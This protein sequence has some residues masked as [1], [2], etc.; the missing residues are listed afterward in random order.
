MG[1][2]NY[3]QEEIRKFF[4]SLPKEVIERE[5]KKQLQEI[6][7]DHKEFCDA[8]DENKCSLCGRSLRYVNKAKPCLHWLLRPKG[9]DKKRILEMLVSGGFGFYRTQGY[10]RWIANYE[11]PLANINTLREEQDKKK[12]FEITVKY[13]N[14]EW[15]INYNQSDRDGHQGTKNNYPHY[16]F[17]MRVDGL[18]F[19]DFSD[20]HIPF[21]DEDLFKLTALEAKV[22]EPMELY[23]ASLQEIFDNVSLEE[24]IDS[25]SSAP[26]D[27]ESVLK[28]DTLIEANEGETISGDEIIKIIKENKK[29]GVPLA[30]LVRKLGH[31][32]T[33]IVSPGE[34]IPEILHRSKRRN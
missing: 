8:L 1:Q 33:T 15:T 23:G 27:S 4:T 31:K 26:S 3:D 24:I 6:E 32:T 7:R 12:L 22:I 17:A 30:T 11:K 34:R 10:L 14:L 28:F 9:A 29:T 19:I 18:P 20:S 16:H 25:S 13:K 2:N 21:T 5:N